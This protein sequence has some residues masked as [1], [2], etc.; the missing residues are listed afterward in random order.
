MT[1]PLIRD[2]QM[3]RNNSLNMK[4]IHRMPIVLIEVDEKI[5]ESP[6]QFLHFEFSSFLSLCVQLY[7][8]T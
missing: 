8:G 4:L 1:A 6:K 5:Y 2:T 7:I 3:F